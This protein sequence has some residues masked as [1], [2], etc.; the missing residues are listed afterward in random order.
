MLRLR[1]LDVDYD[2]SNRISAMNYIQ[3]HQSRGEIVTGL[4]YVDPEANDLH[5]HLNTVER[6]LN[7]LDESELCPG[8]AMLE[9]INA[10]L[11]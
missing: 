2:P 9:R 11:R 10:S 6:P 1:K 5:E 3:E 8:A 4:L 7:A